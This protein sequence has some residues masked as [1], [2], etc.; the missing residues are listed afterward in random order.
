MALMLR[1][2]M[3]DGPDPWSLASLDPNGGWVQSN[4]PWVNTPPYSQEHQS[5]LPWWG[6]LG[7]PIIQTVRD[8]F[9]PVPSTQAAYGA[10]QRQVVYAGSGYTDQ[11]GNVIPRTQAVQPTAGFNS[12]GI[13]LFGTQIG[14]GTVAVVGGIILLVQMP[15]FTR[16]GR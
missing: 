14:W 16:R 15:G 10:Q 12:N 7:A 6:L 8:I 9:A 11:Y 4:D 1:T 5:N 2:G 13:N 3:G